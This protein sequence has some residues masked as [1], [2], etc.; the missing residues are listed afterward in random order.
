M[1]NLAIR[2]ELEVGEVL[3]VV[4]DQEVFL[5][6]ASKAIHMETSPTPDHLPELDFT[7]DWFGKYKILN[8]RH[9]NTGIEH[10]HRNGYAWHRLELEVVQ[11][12]V[13]TF[14]MTV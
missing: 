13:G 12:R 7:E 11:R 8:C 1:I 10:V 14:H 5:D 2:V 3:P 9:V 6:L 4:D